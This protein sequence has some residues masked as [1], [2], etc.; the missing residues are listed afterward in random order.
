MLV[1]LEQS[2]QVTISDVAQ[3]THLLYQCTQ[4]FSRSEQPEEHLLARQKLQ[5]LLASPDLPIEEKLHIAETFLQSDEAE[6]RHTAIQ[7]CV[8]FIRGRELPPPATQH[9]LSLITRLYRYNKRAQERR[10]AFQ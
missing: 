3:A 9:L 7:L 5:E 6:L 10:R 1:D 4:N 8:R 2:D